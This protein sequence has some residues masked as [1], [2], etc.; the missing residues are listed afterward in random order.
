MRNNI[1]LSDDKFLFKTS[2][3]LEGKRVHEFVFENISFI[4]TEEQLESMG[5][6]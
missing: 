2:Y 6:Y 5:Y 1:N 4:V 3:T